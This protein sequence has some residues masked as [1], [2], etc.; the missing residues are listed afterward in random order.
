MYYYAEIQQLKLNKGLALQDI[1]TEI[2]S[3]VVKSTYRILMRMNA[4]CL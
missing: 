3:C 4:K 2:H 1:L